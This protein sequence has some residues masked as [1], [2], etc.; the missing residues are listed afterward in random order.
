MLEQTQLL[1]ISPSVRWSSESGGWWDRAD[2]HS[3]VAALASAIQCY[4][5]G[6]LAMV[7]PW[8]WSTPLWGLFSSFSSSQCGHSGQRR[9]KVWSCKRPLCFWTSVC[10]LGLGERVWSRDAGSAWWLGSQGLLWPSLKPLYLRHGRVLPDRCD[11]IFLR[12]TSLITTQWVDHTGI[13]VFGGCLDS[14]L[15][16]SL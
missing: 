4:V 3:K 11:F 1:W 16:K 6:L 9:G 2:S 8:P 14:T 10:L 5:C 7:K 12:C 15:G 13:L